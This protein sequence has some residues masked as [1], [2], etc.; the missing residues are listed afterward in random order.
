[1]DYKEFVSKPKSM[2]IAPAG[3]GKTHTIVECL[4]YTEG[5]QLILTHTHAGVASIKEKIK[6]ANIPST[7]YS[8]ET[9]SSFAQK[10]VLSFYQGQIPKQEDTKIYYPFIIEKSIELI[11]INLIQ[12]IIKNTYSGLFVDEYQDCNTKHHELILCL[13]EFLPTH[14][15]GDY[16]QGIFDFKG[17]KLVDLQSTS[18]M[19][20]FLS[21]QRKLTEPWRW[22]NGNNS[23]LGENLKSI[24][25]LL[26]E[27]KSI[28]LLNFKEG[29]EILKL[30]TDYYLDNTFR[31]A[32]KTIA[33]DE[34]IL[35]IFP[36]SYKVNPRTNF[37]KMF[38]DYFYLLESID[39]PSFYEDAIFFDKIDKNNVTLEII[40]FLKT[41]LSCSEYISSKHELL[42]KKTLPVKAIL[43]KLALLSNSFSFILVSE[44]LNDFKKLS[45]VRCYRRD[46]FSSLCKAL[47]DAHFDKISVYD[48]MVKR[49][50]VVRRV[51]RKVFGRCLG[52]TLLT[53][54][55]E[56]DTVMVLNADKFDCPKNFYVALTRAS[57][58]LIVVTENDVL[59]PYK[60]LKSPKS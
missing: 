44:I 42:K 20:H 54:G 7:Q 2:L 53:K 59:N 50:N 48:A 22:K 39:A 15:L 23:K 41:N 30:K 12:L 26:E 60:K 56:F 47:E 19:G 8:V 28:N 55:L 40:R 52:T 37:I 10:Y 38:G 57:K 31:D 46:L 16:L 29:I 35:I 3:Y 36:Q 14:I 33:K 5:R 32:L 24:R 51:G 58:R 6:K 13:S 27:K 21:N 1:M 9:I 17:D 45:G 4:R 34:S 18:D 11:K 25:Q 49:R 43:D